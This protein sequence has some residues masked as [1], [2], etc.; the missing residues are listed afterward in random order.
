MSDQE[1]KPGKSLWSS[2]VSSVIDT[3]EKP[4]PAAPKQIA[5]QAAVPASTNAAGT[6]IPAMVNSMAPDPDMIA[7]LQA[8][9]AKKPSP[10]SAFLESAGKLESIIPDETMRLKAAIASITGDGKRTADSILTA[11]DMHINDVEG[12]RMLFKGASDQRRRTEIDAPK[13][14]ADQLRA[15]NTNIAANIEDFQKKIQALQDQAMTNDSEAQTLDAQSHSA[16][17]DITS[18]ENRFGLSVDW[19]KNE[20]AAKKQ[21][22]ASVVT[23]IK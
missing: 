11:I 19:V 4:T 20:L 1:K 6:Y 8:T 3:D 2:I 18:V 23:Q 10:Y 7:G 17:V 15:Q 21:V 12:Q 14:R 9:V 22:L 16:D 5:P 13:A